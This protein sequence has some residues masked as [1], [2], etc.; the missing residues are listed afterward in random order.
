MTPRVG[1]QSA[2]DPCSEIAWHAPVR[3]LRL[4]LQGLPTLATRDRRDAREHTMREKAKQPDDPLIVESSVPALQP[5]SRIQQRLVRS[6]VEIQAEDP[7]ALLFQHSV[8]CQT[9][10]PYR[11]P[12]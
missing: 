3:V 10:L 12:G 1:D 11:D 2:L 7:A 5:L 6:A 9:G 4:H 8:F